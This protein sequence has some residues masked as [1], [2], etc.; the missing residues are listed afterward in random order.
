MDILEFRSMLVVN[1][2]DLDN[3]LERQAAYFDDIS[4]QV[5]QQGKKLTELKD[6][7]SQLEGRLAEEIREDEPK[8]TVGA[9]AHKVKRDRH[10]LVKWQE[11]QDVTAVYEQWDSLR[12]AWKQRGYSI[13]TL[14]ALYG[15]QYFSI[16]STRRVD[17]SERIDREPV[18]DQGYDK[19]RAAMAAK[20]NIPGKSVSEGVIQRRAL[21]D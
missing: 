16:D 1:K 13:K 10:R 8:L 17:R 19:N 12:D 2:H 20:R 4:Q 21:I 9:I 5:I 14:A 6:E 15:D 18:R 11:L 3:A 7:L